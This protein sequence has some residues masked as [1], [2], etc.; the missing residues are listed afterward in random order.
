ITLSSGQNATCTITNNDITPTLTLEKVVVGG[1]YDATDWTLTAT[2]PTGF[3]GVGPT[4]NNGASFD[5]GTYNLSETGP[6][7]YTASDWVCVGGT[8]VDGDTVSLAL[9]ESATCTITN[10][11]IDPGSGGGTVYGCKDPAATNYNAFSS[12]K[13]ELCL[14]EPTITILSTPVVIAPKLPKTGFPPQT[15]YEFLLNNILKLFR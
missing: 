14:Y 5:A 11:Y 4:V 12:S 13:P 10:T 2:G 7:G 3:S 9:G 15:W 6:T 8:T 1:S